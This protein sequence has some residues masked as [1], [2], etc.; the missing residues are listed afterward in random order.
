MS[1]TSPLVG[2]SDH[3][4]GSSSESVVPKQLQQ[5]ELTV[6]RIKSS[7]LVS[8]C[9]NLRHVALARFKTMVLLDL[10]CTRL[11][12]SL[13]SFAGKLCSD[14]ELSQIFIDVF[15]QRQQAQF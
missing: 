1:Q 6:Q 15:P 9:D 5:T 7:R 14:G 12:Q 2:L 8:S 3:V 11:G 13:R 10:G 4:M